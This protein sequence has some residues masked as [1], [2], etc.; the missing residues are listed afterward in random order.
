MNLNFALLLNSIRSLHYQE[1]GL[2]LPDPSEVLYGFLM[3][4]IC[5][6][7]KLGLNFAMFER[8]VIL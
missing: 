8:M 3:Y 6:A 4:S 1:S 2:S 7:A 5:A